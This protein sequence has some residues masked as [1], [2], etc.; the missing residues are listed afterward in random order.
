MKYNVLI[1]NSEWKYASF[2]KNRIPLEINAHSMKE[3]ADYCFFDFNLTLARYM[4]EHFHERVEHWNSN[5]YSPDF[6]NYVL[7][8]REI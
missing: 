1:H 8:I 2:Y 4:L 5:G 6:D 7:E 3:A